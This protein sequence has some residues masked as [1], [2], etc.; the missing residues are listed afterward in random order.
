LA[1]GAWKSEAIIVDTATGELLLTLPG[2]PDTGVYRTSFSPDDARI[3]TVGQDNM[4][5]IWD[6]QTGDLLLS[7]VGHSGEGDAGNFLYGISD[8][9]YSPDGSRLATAGTDGIAKVWDAATG[10]ELL[11][12]AGHTDGLHS[13]A[14]S[15]NGRFIATSSDKEDTTVKVWVAQTGEEIYTLEGHP[16][17]VWGLDFSPDSARLATSGWEGVV[18]VWDLTTGEEIYTLP[19]QITTVFGVAFSPDGNLLITGGGD[20]VRVWDAQT[21]EERFTLAPYQ[22]GSMQ[23]TS[24]G[25][26]VY[27]ISE[28]VIRLFTIPLQ[29]TIALAQTRLTRTLTETECRQYLHLN[30]CPANDS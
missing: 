5:R 1:V 12:L 6:T 7:F 9:A 15:P 16:Q 22:Y 14:Y 26:Y 24:D 19:G 18:K 25:K 20:A 2:E 3:A 27:I 10:E 21:G 29:E 17:R 11:I 28:G 4:V 30:E 13:L 23:F 8:V